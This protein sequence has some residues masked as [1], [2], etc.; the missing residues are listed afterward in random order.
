MTLAH[1]YFIYFLNDSAGMYKT[2]FLFNL[3][4][5]IIF[6]TPLRKHIN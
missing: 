5:K 1:E 2:I 4:D 3:N 6:T